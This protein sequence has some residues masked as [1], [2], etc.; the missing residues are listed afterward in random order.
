MPRAAIVS[1]SSG[2]SSERLSTA[3]PSS[4]AATAPLT[5]A[6][7]PKISLST[8]FKV[9]RHVADE[10]ERLRMRH[11][12]KAEQHSDLARHARRS[13]ENLMRIANEYDA[14]D[15]DASA[16]FTQLTASSSP[17]QQKPELSCRSESS[18][19]IP[20][21]ASMVPPLRTIAPAR[22]P[23]RNIL[24]PAAARGGSRRTDAEPS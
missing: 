11:H 16:T 6:P 23:A 19:A 8:L 5:T 10:L 3:T 15:R 14:L 12:G 24:A 18:E 13:V 2:S 21:E 22:A 17:E 7:P 4:S 20:V 9:G 1:T